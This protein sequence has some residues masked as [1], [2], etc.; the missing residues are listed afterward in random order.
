M[1]TIIRKMKENRMYAGVLL[2]EEQTAPEVLTNTG[3]DPDCRNR[4]KVPESTGNTH[5][6]IG[7]ADI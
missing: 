4:E 3:F 1:K 7:G 2:A 5:Q 6:S